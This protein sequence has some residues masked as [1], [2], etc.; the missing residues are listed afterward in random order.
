MKNDIILQTANLTTGKVVNIPNH[1]RV[2][3]AIATGRTLALI[4]CQPSGQQAF[5]LDL[6][7]YHNGLM[8]IITLGAWVSFDGAQA[9][10]YAVMRA[11]STLAAADPAPVVTDFSDI[12]TPA[13]AEQMQASR[14]YDETI[15]D[16]RASMR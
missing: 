15:A 2:E 9:A 16:V 11:A 13:E 12:Y 6:C 4:S 3:W 8:D 10:F 7:T 14:D 5:R 1:A